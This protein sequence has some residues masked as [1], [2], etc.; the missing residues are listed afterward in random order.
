M[1]QGSET[2]TTTETIQSTEAKSSRNGQKRPQRQIVWMNVYFMLTLHLMALYGI[3]LIPRANPRTWIWTWLCNFLGVLGI[4]CGAHRLWSHRS[5]K[6]KWPLRSLLMIF[7]C[8]AGQ[9]D[10]FEWAR[11]HRVHHKCSET[12]GDPHNAKR[13]LFFSHVG[14]LLV[15]KHPDVIKKGQQLDLSD[16]YEDKI[17][18]FQRRH[19]KLLTALFN[20]IMP[21]V[22]PWYFWNDSLFNTFFICYAFRYACTLNTAWCVN[23]LAHTWG[24]RPYDK[25]INPSQNV[26]VIIGACGDGYHNFH[27][28]FP[29]DYA[30]SE[31]GSPM[32]PSKWLIDICAL[33]GLAYDLK[34]ASPNT[35]LK[36]RMRTGDLQH[37]NHHTD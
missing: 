22:V 2:V 14:W 32:N 12:D 37:L 23:S 5:Y 27:H 10:I 18:M 34:T 17:V 6:A 11:D 26:P 7:D 8:I 1:A 30:S 9:N 4:T 33:L 35:I 31:L 19:Y 13:G 24:A 36:R 29:Q 21:T 3:T 25:N 16:L 15:K 20:V 28:T